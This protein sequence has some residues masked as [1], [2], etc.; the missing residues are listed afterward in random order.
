MP[1]ENARKDPLNHGR[2]STDCEHAQTVLSSQNSGL[3]G[4][5]RTSVGVAFIITVC[6]GVGRFSNTV[7]T[8]VKD[9]D[10]AK[11]ERK[12]IMVEIREIVTVL[13]EQNIQQ[14]ESDKRFEEKFDNVIDQLKDVDD[15][16]RD[17]KKDIIIMQQKISVVDNTDVIVAMR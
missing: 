7:D 10:V 17:N 14:K 11:G 5:I 3:W 12:E 13:R 15:S 16:V 6:V 1:D 8:N 9:I 4:V 2:R